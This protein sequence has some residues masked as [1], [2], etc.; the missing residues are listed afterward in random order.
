MRLDATA[1]QAL[2]RAREHTD[3]TGLRTLVSITEPTG[4]HDPIATFAAGAGQ[5]RMLW[6]LPSEGLW[7]IGIG[8][9][10]S[11]RASG[12][13]R[14]SRVTAAHR[15]L[16]TNAV[17]CG[18]GP[19]GTGPIAMGGFRFDVQSWHEAAWEH[20]GDALLVVPN[21][22]WTTLP[23]GAWCTSN[24]YLVPRLAA[25]C[26][27]PARPLD[28]KEFRDDQV[29]ITHRDPQGNFWHSQVAKASRLIAGG[30]LAK[31]V[32]A[33]RL[34]LYLEEP[35]QVS[36]TLR[37]LAHTHPDCLLFAFEF[38]GR[39]FL[40]ASPERLVALSD[41][42]VNLTCLAGSAPRNLLLLE[43]DDALGRQLLES[44]KQR[45]EHAYVVDKVRE[46]L[47]A[48]CSDVWWDRVPTLSRLPEIQHLATRFRATATPGTH[49]LDLVEALHPSPAVG[50]T[51]A[52]AALEAIRTIEPFDRGWYAGP[53]GWTNADG[54]GEFGIAIRSGL[55]H[56]SEAILYAG[57]GIVTGSDPNAEDAEVQLKF[58]TMLSALTAEAP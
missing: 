15:R 51:P 4:A 8:T 42:S 11:L 43:D 44:S 32:L 58:R 46:T 52:G 33:Q 12:P 28:G 26:D 47:E 9:A 29:A 21:T 41:G 25:E 2:A 39:T 37:Q 5:N 16:M 53:V 49:V 27:P 38:E 19:R 3:S 7:M 50:G 13:G 34:R 55:V 23:A 20:F 57:A 35:I 48:T 36:A 31:V 14:F 1:M 24:R 18:E 54:E 40:G 45:L 10:A 56:K 6:G 22:L 17:L 30:T